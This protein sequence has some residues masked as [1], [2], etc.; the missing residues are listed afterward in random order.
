MYTVLRNLLFKA[1]PEKVHYF[2]MNCLK[3]ATA[4]GIGETIVKNLFQYKPTNLAKEV[5]GLHF[6]NPVGLGAGFDKNAAYLH[7]LEALG[8]GFVEI[9]T[10]TPKGQPG[11]DLPRLFR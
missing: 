6:P 10:V 5:M 4:L 11:N 3:I 9:G 8:F 7:E 1:P 2:S